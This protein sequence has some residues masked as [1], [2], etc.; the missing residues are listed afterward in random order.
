VLDGREWRKEVSSEPLEVADTLYADDTGEFFKTRADREGTQVRVHSESAVQA[1][2]LR[3]RSGFYE[4]SPSPTGQQTWESESESESGWPAGSGVRAS[5]SPGSSPAR[6]QTRESE[7]GR[8]SE[9]EPDV[10]LGRQQAEGQ[11]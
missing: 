7:S 11:Q 8:E 1:R 9:S 10:Q 4:S 2:F 3:V 6:Q 5:P